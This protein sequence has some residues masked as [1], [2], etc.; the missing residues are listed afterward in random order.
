MGS[1]RWI[2]EVFGRNH[3][4]PS[5]PQDIF[6][7]RLESASSENRERQERQQQ[8]HAERSLRIWEEARQ[9]NNKEEA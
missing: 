3:T 8:A 5:G 1:R 9:D 6:R 7:Q 2:D 4:E